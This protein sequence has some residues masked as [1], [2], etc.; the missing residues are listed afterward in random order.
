MELNELF[1]EFISSDRLDIWHTKVEDILPSFILD[2]EV[3]NN[4][5]FPA[6]IIE[7]IKCYYKKQPPFIV[8]IIENLFWLGIS[9]L[10]SGYDSENSLKY[11]GLILEKMDEQSFALPDF[12][13]IRGCSVNERHGWGELD[14]L[15]NYLNTSGTGPRM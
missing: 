1:K 6:N 10:Y 4:E 15:N 8:D 7:E 12:E 14:D 5:Y 3:I 9:N 11:L 13:I 2:V